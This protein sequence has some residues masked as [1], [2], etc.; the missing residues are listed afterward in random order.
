MPLKK[1]KSAPLPKPFKD[2]AA[3]GDEAKIM[4]ARVIKRE[5]DQDEGFSWNQKPETISGPFGVLRAMPAHRKWS[6]LAALGMGG[7]IILGF[8]TAANTGYVK[9]GLGPIYFDNWEASRTSEDALKDKE[10]RMDELKARYAAHNRRIDEQQAAAEA[11]RNAAAQQ[12]EAAR[13]AGLEA[14]RRAA[15]SAT[16]G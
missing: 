13:Q 10:E 14:E 1:P 12:K 8:I 9:P 5:L 16:P 4:A 3:S 2:I 6:A 15:Q 7:G 11:A